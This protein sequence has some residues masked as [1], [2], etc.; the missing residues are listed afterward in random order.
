[1]AWRKNRI[2][3]QEQRSSRNKSLIWLGAL[4]I[5]CFVV[6]SFLPGD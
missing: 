4:A 5:A 2:F 1:M 3:E 6:P